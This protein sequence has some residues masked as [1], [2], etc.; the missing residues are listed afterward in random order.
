MTLLIPRAI[1]GCS[2]LNEGRGDCRKHRGEGWEP[3]F[4]KLDLKQLELASQDQVL[5]TMPT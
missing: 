5:I 2:V 4:S 1:A 3:D